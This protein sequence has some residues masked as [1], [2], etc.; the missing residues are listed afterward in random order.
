MRRE[1]D[2]KLPEKIVVRLGK[3]TYGRQR[4]IYE[5][6][7]LLLILHEPPSADALTRTNRVFLRTPDGKWF[8]NG[9]SEGIKK[10]FL[11]LQQYSELEESLE[12]ELDRA[13]SP[14]RLLDIIEKLTPL[15]RSSHNMFNAI[16]SARETVKS[17]VKVIEARDT[18]YEIQRNFELLHSDAKMALDHRIAKNA[19]TDAAVGREAVKAQHRLNILAA[20]FFPL[21]ALSSLFGMNLPSGLEHLGLPG[22]WIVFT[23]GIILGFIIKGWVLKK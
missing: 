15:V 20:V 17:D 21:T 16:Q 18:A 4:I 23:C 19:E 13:E 5:E 1:Y 10:L 9:R 12:K 8:C 22:F 11:L 7:H 3:Q 14:D 2:W 6:D